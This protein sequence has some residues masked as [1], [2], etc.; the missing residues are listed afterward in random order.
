M[1]TTGGVF[2][3]PVNMNGQP[4]SGLNDPTE[5]TQAARKGYVDNA[6]RKAAPRNLLDNSDFRNPVNQRGKTSIVV[7][8]DV[9]TY[10]IDRWC[11]AEW[12]G[13]DDGTLTLTDGGISVTVEIISFY[14]RFEKG[15]VD[16]TKSYTLAVCYDDGTIEINNNPL[17]SESAFDS[18]YF[19]VMPGKT[20]SW[21]AL[22]EGSYTAETLPE[23]QPKGY[24]AELAECQR[25]YLQ[26]SG[27]EPVAVGYGYAANGVLCVVAIPAMRARASVVI[28]GTIYMRNSGQMLNA[29]GVANY[30]QSENSVQLYFTGSAVTVNVPYDI[31]CAEGAKLALIAD[32]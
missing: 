24:G 30:G 21:A 1:P 16:L 27:M 20:V 25:Y 10:F 17:F 2:T 4:I 22:Y 32:L 23:Y 3:G 5:D 8:N 7:N 28:S 9:Y 11:F 14:Q 31:Y 13:N 15:V 29:S 6:V 18:A 12:S 26:F 19:T